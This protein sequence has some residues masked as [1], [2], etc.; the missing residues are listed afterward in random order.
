MN[1]KKVIAALA[2]VAALASLA[3]CGGVKDGGAATGNTITVGTTDKITSLDPAGSYDN[4]S[5][6]VQIQVF[7]F[8]YS[9]NYN[10]SELSPDCLLY[11][12]PSPR[13]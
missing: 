5:Y 13:D 8:L 6:A 7:P 11:T 10:T 12:S 3:A 2:S 4:G 9:Q 1:R